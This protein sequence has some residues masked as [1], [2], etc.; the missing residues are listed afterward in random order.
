MKTMSAREAKNAFGLMID[1]ARAE[2][3]LIEKHGRGVVMVISVEEYD[4][5][6]G[7]A[8]ATPMQSDGAGPRRID[9]RGTSKQA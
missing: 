2:P 7:S 5:L 6:H 9:D 8:D 3:V 1:T 4:R